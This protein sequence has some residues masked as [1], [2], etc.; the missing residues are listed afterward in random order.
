MKNWFF[1]FLVFPLQVRGERFL[2]WSC[3]SVGSLCIRRRARMALPRSPWGAQAR[4][5]SATL[6]NQWITSLSWCN[7]KK[8]KIHSDKSLLLPQNFTRHYQDTAD[9]MV[10]TPVDCH[11]SPPSTTSR[12]SDSDTSEC[13]ITDY[14]VSREQRRTAD[15][16]SI[17]S[18]GSSSRWVTLRRYFNPIDLK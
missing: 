3:P 14:D 6:A 9:D 2:R 10:T 15:G 17:S 8:K 5:V 16:A 12:L 11:L 1:F 4:G 18:I 13:D 7:R